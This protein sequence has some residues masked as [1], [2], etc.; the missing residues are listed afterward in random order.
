M[1]PPEPP[2][3]FNYQ[4]Y[5]DLQPNTNYDGPRIQ[6]YYSDILYFMIE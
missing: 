5:L 6:S 2:L 1:M 4:L 3:Y